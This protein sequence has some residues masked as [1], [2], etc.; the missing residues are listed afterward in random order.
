MGTRFGDPGPD[1]GAL[2]GWQL[3]DLDAPPGYAAAIAR[4]VVAEA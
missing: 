2:G 3:T 1:A 4:E